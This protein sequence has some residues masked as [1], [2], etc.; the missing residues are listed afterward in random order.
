MELV[1]VSTFY[2]VIDQH[3]TCHTRRLSYFTHVKL[4]VH[5]CRL[6]WSWSMISLYSCSIEYFT[7]SLSRS[8]FPIFPFNFVSLCHRASVS[9]QP[10]T[11]MQ[12]RVWQNTTVCMRHQQDSLT[13]K[14]LSTKFKP[15]IILG[16]IFMLWIYILS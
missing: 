10:D 5:G 2:D 4:K 3:L 12:P 8:I 9:F 7:M 1:N 16:K 11:P 15:T 14:V 6:Q 13:F